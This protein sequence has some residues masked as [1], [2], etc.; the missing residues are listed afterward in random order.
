M[1]T[2]V[3]EGGLLAQVPIELAAG[4][5]SAIA[6]V[7]FPEDLRQVLLLMKHR[8][9]LTEAARGTA[10][11]LQLRAALEVLAPDQGSTPA[12]EVA[13]SSTRTWALELLRRLEEQDPVA[14]VLSVNEDILGAYHF[15][16]D[17]HDDFGINFARISLFWCV[18]GLVS[19]WIACTVEDLTIVVMA[20]ELAHAYTQLGADIDGRRW[21][22]HHFA[23]ADV[24]LK[25]GLAQFYTARALLRL[26]GRFPTALAAF[27]ALLVKQPAP[28]HT[29]EYWEAQFSPE[30][31]RQA[32]LEVR[33]S[34]ERTVDEFDARL[35]RAGNQLQGADNGHS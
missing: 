8:Q 20:H 28:Y 29:H 35:V 7:A 26:Q 18:I 11:L 4:C 24:S 16:T 21:P 10:G 25:E 30:A 12:S 19:D 9:D 17:I 14:R 22:S 13:I 27:D 2:D 34:R 33:R 6:H 1:R 32:M 31:V 3:E 5:P 23:N 15:R